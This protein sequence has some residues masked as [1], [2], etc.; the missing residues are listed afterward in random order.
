MK[1]NYPHIL[2]P[3]HS[4]DVRNS[5]IYKGHDIGLDW[6]SK[7]FFPIIREW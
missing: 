1:L 5:L 6:L 2:C 3:V 4:S 7:W